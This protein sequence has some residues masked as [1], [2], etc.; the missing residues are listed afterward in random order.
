M[1]TTQQNSIFVDNSEVVAII[2]GLHKRKGLKMFELCQLYNYINK[3]NL[4]TPSFTNLAAGYLPDTKNIREGKI[5]FKGI[6][7][8]WTNIPSKTDDM[9]SL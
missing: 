4:S 5:V 8:N 7:V 1:P 6:E 9:F 3:K 2:T